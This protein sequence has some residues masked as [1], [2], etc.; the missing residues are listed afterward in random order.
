MSTEASWTSASS[1]GESNAREIIN[2]SAQHA[3]YNRR[4]GNDGSEEEAIEE[5]SSMP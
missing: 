1:G 5:E 3:A 2:E 4:K